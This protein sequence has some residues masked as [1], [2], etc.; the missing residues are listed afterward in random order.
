MQNEQPVAYGSRQVNTA[1]VN[2]A[3]IEKEMNAIV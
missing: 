3:P 1:E 2:Y